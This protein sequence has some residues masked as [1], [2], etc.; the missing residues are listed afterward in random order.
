MGDAGSADLTP[1]RFGEI[2]IVGGGCYGTFYA[3]QLAKAAERG[4]LTCD[5]VT[6]VDRNP[7]CQARRQLGE[8]GGRRF[9]VA[10]WTRYFDERLAGS[11]GTAGAPDAIVPSPLMPHLM[12]E[13]VARRAAARWPGRRISPAAADEPL[14]T[15]YDVLAPDGTRYVSYAD[16]LCPVHCIEPLTCPVIRAPRSWEMRD[17]LAGAAARMAR[18]RAVAG[19]VVFHCRH[20]VHG[21]GMFDVAEVQAGDAAVAAAGES[22]TEVDVLVGTV[23]SCHGAVSVLRLSAAAIFPPTTPNQDRG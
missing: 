4:K 8:G 12:F 19:P 22:G 21:V 16:W 20:R 1:L 18:T 7:D 2:I 17:A 11:A 3:G 9:A 14:G 15:P 5:A 6:I 13:W 23:S 10:D